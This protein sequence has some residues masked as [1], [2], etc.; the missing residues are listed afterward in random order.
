[1]DPELLRQR[2]AFQKHAARTSSVQQRPAAPP[3]AQ[4]QKSLYAEFR[5][6][7][8]KKTTKSDATKKA[9]MEAAAPGSQSNAINFSTMAKVVDYLKKRHLA[10]QNWPLGFSEV[11]DELQIY[12]LSKKSELWLQE[13]LP[14]NE[15]IITDENGKFRFRPKYKITGEKSLVEVLKAQHENGRGGILLSELNECFANADKCLDALV[16]SIIVVPTVINKRKDKAVFYNDTSLDIE[17]AD[18]FK[19]LWRN[20]SVD[21]L[22][23]KKIEEYLQKKGIDVMKDLAPKRLYNG[24]PKR[25]AI[26]RKLDQKKVHNQ[27]MGDVLEDYE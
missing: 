9:E 21:H 12:G 19:S 11:M 8:K 6:T 26:K 17:L 25:K 3:P 7:K 5:D 22:D 16:P 27:H 10:R 24:P 18:D 4:I 14:K 13:A 20:V 23:E 2:A 15:K 1:M